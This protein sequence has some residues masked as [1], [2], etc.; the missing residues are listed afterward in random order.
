MSASENRVGFGSV[1]SGVVVVL[2]VAAMLT[3]LGGALAG[4]SFGLDVDTL[5]GYR[6]TVAIWLGASLAIGAYLGGRSAAVSSRLMLRRDG[7]LAG[8]VTWGLFTLVVLGLLAAWIS[9]S[10]SI[11]WRLAPQVEGALWALFATMAITLV[12]SLVGGMAGARSEARSIGLR[13]VHVAKRGFDVA[14]AAYERD[15][16][17][18]SSLSSSPALSSSRSTAP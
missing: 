11:A 15:F 9:A 4:T 8:L 18:S 17:G 6:D 14:P 16:F 10:P 2:A 3:A 5:L 12:A 13:S 7:A 1:C